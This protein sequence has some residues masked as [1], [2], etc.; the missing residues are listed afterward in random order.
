[1]NFGDHKNA[2][3]D[4][5]SISSGD[6]FYSDTAIERF[7]QRALD[8]YAG[9]H[10][11]E[12][13]KFAYERPIT[14]SEVSD[15]ANY[16]DYPDDF[17]TDS[18]YRI[19]DDEGNEYD[20]KNWEDYLRFLND[21]DVTDD[22]YIFSSHDRQ[23]FINPTPTST[24]TLSLWGHKKPDTLSND[25]DTH[26]FSDDPDACEIINLYALGLALRK[27]R[28]S[29]YSKGLK[30]IERAREEADVK[31]KKQQAQRA[32]YQSIDN[33]MFN[34]IEIIPKPGGSST[35]RGNFIYTN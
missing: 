32:E 26:P 2:L 4:D 17:Y 30:L 23:F 25:S 18:I 13:T 15:E 29:Y 34:D 19:D 20:K 8:W 21:N 5:L 35:E 28:G 31:W 22:D 16:F 33:Q 14:S 24:I 10:F 1:M 6:S 12:E 27:A 7:I 3:R 11:W 9:L